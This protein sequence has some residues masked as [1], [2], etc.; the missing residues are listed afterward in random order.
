MSVEQAKAFI[1]RMKSDIA[2]KKRVISLENIEAKIEFINSEGFICTEEE[3]NLA[4]ITA[5]SS[6]GEQRGGYWFPYSFS[7][8]HN[9]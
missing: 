5:H 1:K 2:F 6:V 9:L 4:E 8:R 7:T 3:I